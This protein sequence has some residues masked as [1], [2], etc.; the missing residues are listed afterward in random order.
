MPQPFLVV[1]VVFPDRLLLYLAQF[2]QWRLCRGVLRPRRPRR[3]NDCYAPSSTKEI[4][5]LRNIQKTTLTTL[6]R[7]NV[8]GLLVWVPPSPM[9]RVYWPAR[10]I[11]ARLP[12]S[13]FASHERKE[14]RVQ[15]Q[16][17][18]RSTCGS[19]PDSTRSGDRRSAI[20]V[21]GS[22]FATRCLN[23][24]FRPQ[25]DMARSSQT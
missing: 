8:P 15:L 14:L 4:I 1:V 11:R 22:G 5:T 9:D 18:F 24:R 21:R 12:V 13:V 20:S 3:L 10:R 7:S 19:W 25:A 23:G 2:R 17:N 16:V 6:H